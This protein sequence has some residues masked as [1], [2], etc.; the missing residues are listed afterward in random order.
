MNKKKM[1]FMVLGV[2]ILIGV[3]YGLKY[4]YDFSVYKKTVTSVELNEVDLSQIE[5]GTYIGEMDAKLVYAEV[6]V[7][8]KDHEIMAVNLLEHK[9]ERGQFTESI[10]DAIVSEQTIKVDTVSGATNSSLIILKA[11]ENALTE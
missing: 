6:E 3:G 5:D 9:N 1:I 8:V 10:L 7:M 2:L 11:V 4:S